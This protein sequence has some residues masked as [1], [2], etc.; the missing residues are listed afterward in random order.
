MEFTVGKEFTVRKEFTVG[1]EFMVQFEKSE[2]SSSH[3]VHASH[4]AELKCMCHGVH[5]QKR[6][7][8]WIR[9][10]GTIE[11]EQAECVSHGVHGQKRVQGSIEK[12]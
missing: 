1:K 3:I 11:K 5:G 4:G 12:G 10:H 8:S 2:R 6:V 7:H 9:V